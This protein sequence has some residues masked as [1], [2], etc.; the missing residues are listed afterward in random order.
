LAIVTNAVE[1]VEKQTSR[2]KQ[3]DWRDDQEDK[4]FGW[5]REQVDQLLAQPF[6]E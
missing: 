1:L 4:K 5:A 6:L 3:R 2:Q